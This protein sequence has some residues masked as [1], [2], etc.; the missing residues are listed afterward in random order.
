[1]LVRARVGSTD[2]LT[3]GI[4]LRGGRHNRTGDAGRVWIRGPPLGRYY[5]IVDHPGED[6]FI[7]ISP[8]SSQQEAP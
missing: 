6:Y 4:N 5:G 1:M 7:D 3:R 2:R 8:I